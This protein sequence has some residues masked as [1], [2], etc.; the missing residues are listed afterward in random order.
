MTAVLV[1]ASAAKVHMRVTATT[2][3]TL[4]QGLVDAAEELFCVQ[5]GR[6]DRPFA[7]A[8][9]GRSEVH[10]GTGTNLLTVDYP[11]A[12]A[13]GITSLKI[14]TDVSDPSETLT[15]TDI[16]D[17]TLAT[18]GR[19]IW[20]TDGGTFGDWMEPRVVHITY[21]HNAD[22]TSPG[23]ALAAV[24]I[25]R[26][27]AAVYR[28]IGSEDAKS[29]TLPNGYTRTLQDVAKGDPVWTVA[30]DAMWEPEL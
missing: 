3:D 22:T 26:A 11:I 24:A 5:C 25:K 1:T 16:D 12:S 10:A 4:I 8:A 18:G 27:V 2:D 29:E 19:S 20:R 13:S 28:Q 23:A 6:K 30:V 14:G 9:T 7:T 15:A 17:V 21:N